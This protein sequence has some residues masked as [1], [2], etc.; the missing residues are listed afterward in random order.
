MFGFCIMRLVL[1]SLLVLWVV[2]DCSLDFY[3]WCWNL[4]C[5]GLMWVASWVCDFVAV[6]LWLVFRLRVFGGLVCYLLLDLLF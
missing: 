2:L 3:C 6:L 4:I 5:G 1:F